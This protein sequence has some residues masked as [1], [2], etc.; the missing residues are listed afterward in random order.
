M[1]YRTRTLLKGGVS[2]LVLAGV[3]LVAVFGVHRP[4]LEKQ[5]AEL[6]AKLVLDMDAAAVKALRLTSE[7]ATT[8]LEKT[9]TDEKQLATWKMVEPVQD[10]ADDMAVNG[11][12]GALDRLDFAS[13]ISGEDAKDLARYGLAPPRGELRVELADGK[14]LGL[15]IGKVN[16]FSNQ[17]YIQREG[18]PDVLVTASFNESALLKKSFDLRRKEILRFEN[19]KVTKLSLAHGRNR[20]ELERQGGAWRL[21]APLQ[22]EADEAE[23]TNLLNALRNL[24]AASFPPSAEPAKAFGLDAPAVTANLTLGDQSQAVELLVGADSQK[25]K[26]FARR[27]DPP[28]PLAEIREYQQK[29]VQK[30]AFDLQ[31]R[32]PVRFD[33]KAVAKVKLASASE[34]IVLEKKA[35]EIPAEDKQPARTQDNWVILSPMSAP[36]RLYKVTSLLSTLSSLKASRF[37]GPKEGANLAEFGLDKPE[38]T[39]TL[40]DREDKEIGVLQVGK[41]T[42]EGTFV[43]GTSRPQVCVVDSKKLE[44]LPKSAA[45]L[46]DTPAPDGGPA[47]P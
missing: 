36:A 5:K 18:D 42:G 26:F 9:G 29:N 20:V 32:S 28:G 8:R 38:R 34:L 39:I 10:E 44:S 7:G 21:V 4:R 27:S 13:R 37:A 11:L 12:V 15:K 14:T 2:L 16:V 31:A 33:S 23:V 40:L 45:D 19:D 17:L 24:R 1:T 47:L 30:T 41:S 35:V 3:V 43:L 6:A 46:A 25:G 22:D